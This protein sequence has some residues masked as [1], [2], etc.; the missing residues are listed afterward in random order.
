MRSKGQCFK[1][2]VAQCLWGAEA[3]VGVLHLLLLAAGVL[4]IESSSSGSSVC[5]VLVSY[6]LHIIE[7]Y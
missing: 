3:A 7:Y 5:M 2:R 4:Y 6:I 1:V